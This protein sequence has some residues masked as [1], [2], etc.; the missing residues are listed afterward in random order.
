MIILLVA[1]LVASLAATAVSA[2][3]RDGKSSKVPS[4][5]VVRGVRAS[6]GA[7]STFYHIIYHPF[8]NFVCIN[9]LLFSK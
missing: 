9:L 3:H 4:V 5:T 1:F 6:P 7:A 8:F 2:S